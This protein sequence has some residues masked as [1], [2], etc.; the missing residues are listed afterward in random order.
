MNEHVRG[1]I[2]HKD[3]L[4]ARGAPKPE[5]PQKGQ[6]RPLGLAPL[7]DDP[8]PVSAL[9]G[10]DA[11]T[12]ASPATVADVLEA[13]DVVVSIRS[14]AYVPLKVR[15][16]RLESAN[17]ELRAELAAS[18]ADVATLQASLAKTQATVK[19]LRLTLSNKAELKG[20]I[21]AEFKAQFA[22]MH[23]ERI[24]RRAEQKGAK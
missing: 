15:L 6:R 7:S 5:A 4:D 1:A 10:V 24:A 16:A 21:A 9:D 23:A 19:A 22:A 20:Q 18:R 17:G 13:I 3:R 2:I 12:L 11:A 8:S 14:E